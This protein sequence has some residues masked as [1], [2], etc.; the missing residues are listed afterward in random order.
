[1]CVRVLV[2]WLVGRLVVVGVLDSAN[3]SSQGSSGGGTGQN[4][5]RGAHVLFL[6]FGH[7]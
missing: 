3:S 1:M 5:C 6:S 2:C 7:Q 4:P